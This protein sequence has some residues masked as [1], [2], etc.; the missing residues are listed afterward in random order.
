M[1]RATGYS[2]MAMGAEVARYMSWPGQATAYYVGLLHFLDLREQAMAGLGDDFDLRDFHTAV[3]D[4]GAMPLPLLDG[5]VD[6]LAP[7]TRGSPEHSS[8][9]GDRDPSR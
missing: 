6:R 8:L 5:R 1:V 4:A 3:L 2:S 9:R 7:P